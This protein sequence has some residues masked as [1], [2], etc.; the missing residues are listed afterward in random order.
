MELQLP[1]D[2]HQGPSPRV[3]HGLK[4]LREVHRKQ[5]LRQI[6]VPVTGP[7]QRPAK[8]LFPRQTL[9]GV[10]VSVSL[11]LYLFQTKT[12]AA[13][14]WETGNDKRDIK[15]RAVVKIIHVSRVQDP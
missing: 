4:I 2:Q 10:A 13:E 11:R 14:Y 8:A 3:I 1:L 9:R 15:P 5:P 7:Q 6:R 12:V